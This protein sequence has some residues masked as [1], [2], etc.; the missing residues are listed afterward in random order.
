MDLTTVYKQQLKDQLFKN[1]TNLWDTLGQY[2]SDAGQNFLH[3]QV[4][5][6]FN[7]IN[8]TDLVRCTLSYVNTGIGAG[9][10]ASNVVTNLKN[11]AAS[12]GIS[13][14]QLVFDQAQSE[15]ESIIHEITGSVVNYVTTM[16]S[17]LVLDT[18]KKLARRTTQ[19]PINIVTKSKSYFLQNQRPYSYFLNEVFQ[20]QDDLT[21]ALD[22]EQKKEEEKSFIDKTT[23]TINNIAGKINPYLSK[24]TA[25]INGVMTYYQAGPDILQQYIME[26]VAQIQSQ[27][28]DVVND[29]TKDIYKEIDEFENKQ[30]SAIGKKMV[31]QYEAQQRKLANKAKQKME[32]SKTL[33][34]LL[35]NSLKQKAKLEIMAKTGVSIL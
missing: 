34:K 14:Q 17:E 4:T 35:T 3:G 26:N 22:E 33:T 30:S 24:T 1:Q 21:E 19:M 27:I 12:K 7:I 16:S 20:N 18:T 8:S 23:Y 9:K 6:A 28:N 11:E 31:E 10:M 13:V 15:I 29:T 5:N 25:V 2:A 32:T